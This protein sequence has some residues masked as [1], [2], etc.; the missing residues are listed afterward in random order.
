[1]GEGGGGVELV[2]VVGRWWW[3]WWCWGMCALLDLVVLRI[4]LRHIGLLCSA[5]LCRDSLRLCF[6][7]VYVGLL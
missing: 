1:M 7:V 6:V 5:L 4:A 3:R 2:V